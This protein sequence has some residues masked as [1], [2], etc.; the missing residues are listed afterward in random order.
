M[1][2]I[3]TNDQLGRKRKPN[4]M[5]TIDH[6]ELLNH[7]FREKLWVPPKSLSTIWPTANYVAFHR[8]FLNI[9]PHLCSVDL[10]FVIFL[11][12][13]AF[14]WNVKMI[15]SRA[16]TQHRRCDDQKTLEFD[17]LHLGMC[18]E[19]VD[20]QK[21]NFQRTSAHKIEIYGFHLRNWVRWLI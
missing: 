8:L 3:T 11:T 16:L 1:N 19:F 7:A 12:S 4:T 6:S 18:K 14:F 9:F 2:P 13:F 20:C 21:S 10:I 17:D 15:S 5:C